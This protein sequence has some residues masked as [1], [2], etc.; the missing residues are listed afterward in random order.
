[1]R[2]SFLQNSP[3]LALSYHHP[4]ARAESK[5]GQGGA[6]RYDSAHGQ[7]RDVRS[8]PFEATGGNSRRSR[9]VKDERHDRDVE[10]IFHE[11]RQQSN[12]EQRAAYL[13]K[14]CASDNALRARVEKLL[15][16]E[17]ELG[18]FMRSTDETL[19]APRVVRSGSGAPTIAIPLSEKPGTVIGR[20]KLLQQIGEG[21]FGVVYMA[22]QEQPVRRKVALKIIKLGMDTLQIIARFEAERQALAMMD[23]PHIA[24]VLDAGATDRG[25]PYFVMELVRG[26]PITRYCDERQLD[27]RR[28]LAL[29][30]EV[31]RGIQHAHHRVLR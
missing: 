21:G 29:F 2:R 25:S 4:F 26:V 9:N 28:R 30:G 3:P 7:M 12:T 5:S 20:Y 1:M 8:R 14:A 18:S 22:E 24:K 10:A 15:A 19:V 23:H 16:A 31:C 13:E 11:A 17:A 27:V 6:I